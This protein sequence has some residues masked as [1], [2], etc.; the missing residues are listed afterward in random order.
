LQVARLEDGQRK[1]ISMHEINGMEGDIITMS[2]LFTF[3][4]EG[5]DEHKRV[6]GRLRATGI[7]PSFHKAL[8]HRGIDL[9]VEVFEP[10]WSQTGAK[11]DG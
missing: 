2:E 4:R 10:D 8:A 3:Q 1:L 6:A 11:Y 9:P 7:I 5:F